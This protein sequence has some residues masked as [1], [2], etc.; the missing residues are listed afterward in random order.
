[1]SKKSARERLSECRMSGRICEVR[2]CGLPTQKWGRLCSK[3][4]KTEENTGH[5]SGRTIRVSELQPFLDLTRPYIRKNADHPA[6][7]VALRWLYDLIHG[8]RR[9]TEF[10]PRNAT[11]EDRLGRW[12]D[13]T[14]DQDVHEADALAMIAALYLHREAY[15]RDFKSDRHFRHQLVI[16]FLRMVRAP[17]V[18]M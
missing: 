1:M 8:P 17:R 9:R 4:D 2:G 3:H 10:L 16:R 15:P 7:A 11:P 18:D 6:I 5:H 12:L 14:K 13:K